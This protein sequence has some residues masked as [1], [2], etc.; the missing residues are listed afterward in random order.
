MVAFPKGELIQ[1]LTCP[2]ASHCVA[3]GLYSKVDPRN[4]P[5]LDHGV[6]LTSDDGGVTWQRHAWPKGYGPGVLPDV[7]CADARHCAMI[8]FIERN[9][10]GALQTT[11]T[12]NL[13]D[14]VP[15]TPDAIIAGDFGNGH[16][17]LAVAVAL[18]GNATDDVVVLM[19]DGKGNFQPLAPIPVG[20]APDAFAEGDFG[21]GQT[22]LAVADFLSGDVMILS[23]LGGGIFQPA[24]TIQPSSMSDSRPTGVL[25][26]TAPP[27][28]AARI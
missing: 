3:V 11:T 12:I 23:N 24:A 7:T 2:T 21:N 17:D 1:S 25:G 5:D 6:L 18:T 27:L 10:S 20:L 13:T 16:T 14:I 15:G 8:G 26:G 28:M 4:G 19:G 22:D 9:G